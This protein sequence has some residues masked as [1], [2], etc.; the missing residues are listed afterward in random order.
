[1][2]RLFDP[3][4]TTKALGRGMG[5][6]VVLGIVQGHEGGITICS[7]PGKGTVVNVFLPL[8]EHP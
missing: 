8:A 2:D 6:A 4:F 1:M 3:F 5:L 7:Q